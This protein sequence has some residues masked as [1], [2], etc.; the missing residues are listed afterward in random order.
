MKVIHES[1]CPG[2]DRYG[3]DFNTCTY[4]K[5]WAQIDTEK[6]AS[7]FGQW[8]QPWRRKVCSYIEGDVRVVQF[9]TTAELADYLRELDAW[10][11]KCGYKPVKI[12]AG[13]TRR[14]DFIDQLTAVGVAD[15]IH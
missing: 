6:D 8:V 11:Q 14:Q 7:Y 10:N 1:N 5:G 12:D 9:K 13:L 2:I 4:A 3:F 15:M